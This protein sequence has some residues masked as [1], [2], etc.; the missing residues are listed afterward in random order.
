[1]Y[2]LCSGFSHSGYS[3]L[4]R[5][6]FPTNGLHNWIDFYWGSNSFNLLFDSK[7]IGK[8]HSQIERRTWMVFG[9]ETRW[10]SATTNSSSVSNASTV[11][12][13][14]GCLNYWSY[15]SWPIRRLVPKILR[16]FKEI[17]LLTIQTAKEMLR[18]WLRIGSCCYY[19]PHRYPLSSYQPIWD[20]V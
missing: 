14:S 19:W 7:L 17:C 20:S 1:M 6:G 10:D 15:F 3:T 12:N 5:S 18:V 16:I 8:L 4:Y 2:L 13:R 11:N 9:N